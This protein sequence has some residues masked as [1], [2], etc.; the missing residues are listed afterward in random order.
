[1]RLATP[2]AIAL[3]A[4]APLAGCGGSS[5]DGSSSTDSTAAP[6]ANGS[7]AP[8]GASAHSC[9]A[10]AVDVRALRVTGISC[11]LG[12]RVMF[13]WQRSRSCAPPKGASRSSCAAGPY[14]CLS[15][16]TDRGLVVS[17]ARPSES[18]AFTVRR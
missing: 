8:V 13:S 14:R 3:I 1:M 2:I 7:A 6:K 5:E 18:V 15:V 10:H 9:D 17:C 4:A 11:E 16:R 12:R